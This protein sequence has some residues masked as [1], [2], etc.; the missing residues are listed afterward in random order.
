MRV[1]PGDLL[2]GALVHHGHLQVRILVGH[3]EVGLVDRQ[4][5]HVAIG[6]PAQK[7]RALREDVRPHPAAVELFHE[8]QPL[9]GT[10]ALVEEPQRLVGVILGHRLVVRGH[11]L[12]GLL[13]K[14]LHED[15]RELALVDVDRVHVPPAGGVAILGA[16]A[17][18][19]AVEEAAVHRVHRLARVADEGLGAEVRSE[20]VETVILQRGAQLLRLG[21]VEGGLEAGLLPL[22][23]AQD[24]DPRLR[25]G[26]R[27]V[28][29]RR[30]RELDQLR[31]DPVGLVG[32]LERLVHDGPGFLGQL[33]V[34]PLVGVDPLEQ[35]G[36]LD[37][38]PHLLV[39]HLLDV[40]VHGV[41]DLL[42]LL[43]LV[44]HVL[45]ARVAFAQAVDVLAAEILVDEVQQ[46]ALGRIL[47]GLLGQEAG[48]DSPL[49]GLLE[50]H[51]LVAVAD[52]PLPAAQVS[53]AELAAF[54]AQ[55]A[56]LAQPLGERL[57]EHLL[58]GRPG[59]LA[60]PADDGVRTVEAGAVLDLDHGPGNG[61][62]RVG[63]VHLEG[64]AP[65]ALAGP[66]PELP[67]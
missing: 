10:V 20:R 44:E 60:Q 34:V 57:P 8:W 31:P 6:H 18:R 11:H 12:R 21:R 55:A 48:L 22:E 25:A 3:L 35:R 27:L 59:A 61:Q 40:D 30:V 23:Q 43:H 7:L 17:A 66:L 58:L 1:H 37:G 54:V 65:E 36:L 29:P 14:A 49:G 46:V 2:V 19:L 32:V 38:R 41:E 4:Q 33:L 26:N 45:H 50:R 51:G 47:P 9:H 39:G 62:A 67:V 64:V 56:A 24:G 63:L 15:G 13:R 42:E 5:P 52:E 16:V 53:S 28:G